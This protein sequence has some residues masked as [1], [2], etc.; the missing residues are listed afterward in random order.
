M[1]AMALGKPVITT[2]FSGN[3]DFMTEENSLLIKDYKM[4]PVGNMEWIGPWYDKETM[5][6]ADAN[7]DE[8]KA[9]MRYV[10]EH[11]E[12][13][14][15]VGELARTDI[16]T[17]FTQEACGRH[18]LDTVSSMFKSYQRHSVSRGTL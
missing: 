4:V 1:E 12:A 3:M 7:I 17:K 2:G 14:S 6:W 9:K 11:Q 16:R 10:Y 13:A 5:E 15:K 8:L 18:I